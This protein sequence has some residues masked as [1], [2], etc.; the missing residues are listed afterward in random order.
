MGSSS[1]E[2]EEDEEEEERKKLVGS[3]LAGER[4]GDE[5]GA[6]AEVVWIV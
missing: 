5:A 1:A 3:T 4:N 2:A 6:A